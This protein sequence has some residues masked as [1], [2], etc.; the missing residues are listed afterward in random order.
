MK[1]QYTTPGFIRKAAVASGLFLLSLAGVS[2]AATFG[3]RVIDET[4]QPVSGASVCFGLPGSYKQFGAVFTDTEGQATASVPN[5]PFIVTVSKT[6]FSGMRLNEPGRGFNLIKQVTLTSGQPGPRCKAG[7]TLADADHS[8]IK[9]SQV[10]VVENGSSINISPVSTGEPT[11]YRIS[12]RTADV[13][14]TPWQEFNGS[15]R[16]SASLANLE[17][18]YLQLRRYEGTQSGWIEAVSRTATVYLPASAPAAAL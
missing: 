9:I 4:G 2:D 10:E 11:H 6:R 7:T 5:V 1:T 16:L 8:S 18:V 3:V 13:V 15:F 14:N 17:E 12:S